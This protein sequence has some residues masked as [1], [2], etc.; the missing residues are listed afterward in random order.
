MNQKA[1]TASAARDG[2]QILV[3]E[4]AG[5]RVWGEE[6]LLLAK[7]GKYSFKIL[8]YNPGANGNLQYHREKDES[9]YI[10]DGSLIVTYDQGDHTLVETTL[11]P[12]QAYNFPPGAVHKEKAGPEGCVIIEVSTCHFNDRVRCEIEYGLDE[13]PGLPT[14]KRED[15]TE[16]P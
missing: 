13:E 14:T 15:I 10:V 1:T 16:T 12:G 6:L 11:V 7:P 9:G 8:K 4:S 2:M 3:P 5:P